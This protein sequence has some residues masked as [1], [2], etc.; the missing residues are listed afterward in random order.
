MLMSIG[1]SHGLREAVPA[2][3]GFVAGFTLLLLLM[4]LG[5]GAIH[6]AYPHLHSAVKFGGAAYMIWLA[7]GLARDTSRIAPTERP[8]IGLIGAALLQWANPKAWVTAAG[9]VTIYVPPVPY[10]QNLMI[11]IATVVAVGLPCNAVW[12][13]G[14]EAMQR[15]LTNPWRRRCA[16]RIMAVLLVLSIIPILR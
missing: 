1:L 2:I 13:V 4:G 11:A 9:A 10:A 8:P 12:A 15:A 3:G 7:A 16:N 5:L 14:G 6:T